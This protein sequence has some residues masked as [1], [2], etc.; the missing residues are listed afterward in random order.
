MGAASASV[1]VAA[2]ASAVGSA[3]E[4]PLR[5]IHF[6]SNKT[7]LTTALTWLSTTAG[8][9]V[10]SVVASTALSTIASVADIIET[11]DVSCQHINKRNEKKKTRDQ[12]EKEVN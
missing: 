10:D 7:Q 4:C 5:T 8:A 11:R 2:S 1:V 3:Y 9:G 12:H 6:R